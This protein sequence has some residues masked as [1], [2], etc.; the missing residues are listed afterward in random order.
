MNR[1][2]RNKA[3]TVSWVTALLLLA[4]AQLSYAGEWP[5][6]VPVEGGTIVVYQPQPEELNGNTLTGRAAM[7]IEMKNKKDPIYGV[8]WFTMTIE[9]D[10][11]EDTVSFSNVKVTKVTWPDSKDTGEQQ[12]KQA[13]EKALNNSSFE[14]SLSSM[15]AALAISEKVQ[16]SL[17]DINNDPPKIV[18]SEELAV[19]SLFDGKPHFEEV[20]N[21][22]YERA[23]N[24]ALVIVR[25]TKT[26]QFYLTSGS[27]WYQSKD[28]MGPWKHTTSPPADLVA[29]IPKSDD[30]VPTTVPEI[31][32]ANEPTELIVSNGKP[33][34]TSLDGG[35]LLYVK[36]T[37]TPWLR[38]LASGNMYL[39][40]SGRWF[41]SGNQDGPWVFVRAD[42]LP[43]AFK[44]IPP[45]SDIGG[46]RTSIAG[47]DEANEAIADAQIPQ[48]AAI[49]RSEA[50]LTVT[51]DG[52]PK[53]EAIK[54]TEVA[55]AVNTAAQVLR[56]DG[57]FYAV[58]NGVWFSS[59]SAEGPW[60][61]A[62][63]VPSDKIAAIPPSSPVYN[64]TY[65]TVYDSTPEVVYVGYTPGYM[66]SYP[67]YGVPVY[68]TGWYY[69]PYVG[70]VYYPRAPTWGLH[71][72]YNPWTGWNF[73]VSW[74][75]PFL[76]VGVVW[77][78]GY[79]G[80][81]GGHCCGGRYGGGYHHNDI[82]INTGDINIGNNVNVG[83][84]DKIGNNISNSNRK[85]NLYNNDRNSHRNADKSALKG[86]RQVA[87]SNTTRKNDLYAGKNGQVARKNS[88]QWQ[89][90]DNNQWKDSSRNKPAAAKTSQYNKPSTKPAQR[91]QS[92]PQQ[93][94]QQLDHH[95]MNR[96]A[97]ARSRGGN[98]GGGGRR[99]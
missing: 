45:A 62:D 80:Y 60:I 54:G 1:F 79:H 47:T 94:R 66:W 99:R 63:T 69:P 92:R 24:T 59:A 70:A 97:H 34:W 64:T 23:L 8:F 75:G 19:L 84:R 18:F 78:G 2:L 22:P 96:Q 29:M 40:L 15:T 37:E 36:N 39:Q 28:A 41:R 90:R 56:V 11:G 73:G 57:K 9:T 3:N 48:T 85:N 89:V 7:S 82:N 49:K 61:V 16:K 42:K 20:E 67:Y 58:D 30:P 77:G 51:Y 71:V 6:E 17:E 65:V 38:D 12:F 93:S 91:P 5:Q 98:R 44:E 53:F 33:E 68:G 52:K 72:G 88:D 25:N 81:H 26:K 86:Q 50:K 74:G 13:T 87:R 32:S 76:R 83:N 55:Y 35:K 43:E 95:S 31:V 14:G 4:V 21:S 10:R 46:V 27:L